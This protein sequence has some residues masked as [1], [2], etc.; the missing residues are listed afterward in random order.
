MEGLADD[1]V[2]EVGLVD[3]GDGLAKFGVA[4]V[5]VDVPQAADSCCFKACGHDAAATAEVACCGGVGWQNWFGGGS[6]MWGDF[7]SI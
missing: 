4:I 2:L 7:I 3:L 6:P 5:V 1:W